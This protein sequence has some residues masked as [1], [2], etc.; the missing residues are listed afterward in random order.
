M[1]VQ[2]GSPFF[3]NQTFCLCPSL[4]RAGLTVRPYH[5]NVPSFGE[6]GFALASHRP[7]VDKPPSMPQ[8]R[9]ISS[10]IEPTLFI[11]SQDLRPQKPV[12]PTTLA[13]PR[14][15]EYFNDDWRRWN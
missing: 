14:I 3:A 10:H 9:F 1:A 12:E 8:G 15:V 13:H 4:Q 2:I 7:I 11:F 5:V 6:W